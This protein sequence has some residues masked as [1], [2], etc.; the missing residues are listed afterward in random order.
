MT[1]LEARLILSAPDTDPFSVNEKWP[2][3]SKESIL[4]S[5]QEILS[6]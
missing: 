1:Q 6:K 5:F 2:E 3:W 4:K